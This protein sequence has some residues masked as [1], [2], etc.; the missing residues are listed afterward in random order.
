[1]GI[2]GLDHEIAAA[3]IVGPQPIL[4]VFA[5]GNE[6]HRHARMLAK[7][8]AGLETV[9]AGQADIEQQQIGRQLV[10]QR[11]AALG[12]D[13][14]GQAVVFLQRKAQ[15][16]DNHRIIFDDHDQGGRG[17]AAARVHVDL[18]G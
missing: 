3:D 14:A 16:F 12:R 6:D 13:K 18:P 2:E 5:A 1:M 11:K 7:H 15:G 17:R 10:E 4:K 8:A 9:A